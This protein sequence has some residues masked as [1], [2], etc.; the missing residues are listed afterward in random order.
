MLRKDQSDKDIVYPLP[1]SVRRD[2]GGR[3]SPHGGGVTHSVDAGISRIDLE[4]H[5]SRR[6]LP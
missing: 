6:Y 1:F 2:L 4:R 5:W 3:P